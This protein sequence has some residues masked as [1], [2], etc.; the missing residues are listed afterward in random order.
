MA[1]RIPASSVTTRDMVTMVPTE[2]LTF[3]DD[4]TMSANMPMRIASAAVAGASLSNGMNDSAATAAA[5]MPTATDTAMSVPLAFS[6]PLAAAIIP[7]TKS[8]R[9][10]TAIMPL[11]SP[12]VSIVLRSTATPARIATDAE[13]SNRLAPTLTM[14]VLP[15]LL[16]ISMTAMMPSTNAATLVMEPRPLSKSAGSI[17]ESATATPA[18][19]AIEAEIDRSALPI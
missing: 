6:A 10:P 3:L 19:M 7:A 1:I 16:M 18:R 11:V 13:T 14:S 15:S 2:A 8:D 17:P 9:N 12:A 4:C 5:R